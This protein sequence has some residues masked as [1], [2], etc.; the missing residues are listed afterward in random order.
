[1]TFADV[2]CGLIK[3]FEELI[4]SQ[5][6]PPH[7]EHMYIV[8]SKLPENARE[9]GVEVTMTISAVRKNAQLKTTL[10]P[11]QD[12][13]FDMPSAVLERWHFKVDPKNINKSLQAIQ[14][15]LE[16]TADMM[17]RGLKIRLM[18]MPLFPAVSEIEKGNYMLRYNV[19]IGH[20]AVA[21]QPPQTT[22]K[23]CTFACREGTFSTTVCFTTL[24]FT[25]PEILDQL[26]CPPLPMLAAAEEPAVSPTSSP[27]LSPHRLADPTI[28]RRVGRMDLPSPSDYKSYKSKDRMH[29]IQNVIPKADDDKKIMTMPPEEWFYVVEADYL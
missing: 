20:K 17:L 22:E 11:G 2:F 28:L 9:N 29:G 19:M 27:S 21:V 14:S 6:I 16:R 15:T 13:L 8:G 25:S 4:L 5:Y 18:M 7:A 26:L 23:V 3:R 24:N 12:S 10:K 1:M